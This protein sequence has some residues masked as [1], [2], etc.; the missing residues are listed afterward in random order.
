MESQVADPKV[1]Y[2]NKSAEMTLQSEN[3]ST[4][5]EREF[6]ELVD[7]LKVLA[8]KTR[9]RASADMYRNYYSAQGN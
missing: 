8:D 6:D 3:P 7:F 4:T 9:I 1:W 2:R 5:T